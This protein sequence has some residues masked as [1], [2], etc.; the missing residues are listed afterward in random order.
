MRKIPQLIDRE[1]GKETL[2]IYR[3]LEKIE[4]KISVLKNHQRFL[5]RKEVIPVGLKLKNI[6]RTQKGDCI[7]HKAERKLLNERIRNINNT[8]EHYEHDRYMYRDQLKS[9]LRP[10]ICQL[11]E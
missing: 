6:I 9:I 8:I 10:D 11:C 3:K 1:Y 7:I 2:T 4:L 5:L